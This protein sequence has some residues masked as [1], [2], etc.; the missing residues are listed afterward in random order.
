MELKLLSENRSFNGSQKVFEHYSQICKCV[1]TFGLF[2]PD[3]VAIKKVPVLWFLSGLT[4]THEN[5]MTKA[6][7]QQW[8]SENNLALVFPDTSPRG[9]GIPNHDDYDL[10]Q[11]AGFYLDATNS[12]WNNNFN[13]E[14]YIKDELS[15][16]IFCNFM[17]DQSKQGITG[18]SMGGLGALNFALKNQNQYLSASAFSPISN[19][20]ESDWGKKQFL[21]YL[22]DDLLVW[23]DYDPS[24]LLKKYGFRTKLLID[25]G[26]DDKFFD[27]LMPKS[28]SKQFKLNKSLG[29]FRY[30]RGYD[31]SYFFVATFIKD[32]IEHH[33]NILST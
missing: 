27:L 6:G 14:T 4:C 30:H 2:L 16:L 24:I 10:G 22:E 17:L 26:E 23:R 9:D 29:E 13:M 33:A 1:M 5:A 28:L 21:A 11:G 8:A 32:H 31:H 19:P 25:Q 12:P 18:H 15:K 3:V 7:A 20:T